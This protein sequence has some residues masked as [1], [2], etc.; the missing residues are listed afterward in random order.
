MN[1]HDVQAYFDRCAPMW[2]ARLRRPQAAIDAILNAAGLRAGA[3]VLDVACGT[4]VLFEDYL[5]RGAGRVT[6]VD[7]SPQMALLARR[8]YPQS[9]IEVVC[10]DIEEADLPKAY[11]CC[12]VYN[13]LPH[14]ADP[15]RLVASL[16]RYVVAG[17]RLCIAHSMSRAALVGHHAGRAEDV[18]CDIPEAEE[19][20]TVFMPYFRCDTAVSDDA[21]Y[22]VAGVRL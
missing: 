12:V 3:R 11:D 7:L 4:G 19:L 21:M 9:H 2:D 18:S 22:I 8:K 5:A 17:G 10:A 13:A 20:G 14:F 15:A 1:K 16:S 6:G